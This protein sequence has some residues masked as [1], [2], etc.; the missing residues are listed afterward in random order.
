MDIV[1]SLNKDPFAIFAFILLIG[2]LGGEVAKRIP[3]LPKISGYIFAGFLIGPGV[4][5]IVD[6]EQLPQ[7]NIFINISLGLIMFEMGRYLHLPWFK[8]DKGLLPTVLIESFLTFIFTFVI[9]HFYGLPILTN[10]IISILL[11][12]T[13]PAIVMMVTYDLLAEGPVTRRTLLITSFNNLVCI[14]LYTLI[15]PLTQKVVT[16][17]SLTILYSLYQILGSVCLGIIIFLAA[18]YIALFLG[19]HREGQFV[20]YI[21]I[22]TLTIS[23]ATQLKLSTT[24]SLFFLG[25]AARNF[26]K[27]QALMEI[28]FGWFA[29]MFFIILFVT[30]G[31][32]LQFIQIKVVLFAIFTILIARFISK[33]IALRCFAKMSDLSKQQT[34]SIALALYPV[35]GAALGMAQVIG[36]NNPELNALVVPIVGSLVA[37]MH[38]LGPIATQYAFVKAKEALIIEN[39]E[40]R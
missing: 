9:L 3:F 14:V 27:K 6:T 36:E 19:K 39:P 35:G 37:I 13:A 24:I 22:V 12:G 25:V 33:Y 20:L 30:N 38:L 4:F 29:R 8:H 16:T 21:C 11:M 2:L 18:R 10:I 34:T 31:I 28:D 23:L 26:D 32:Y 5:N 15:L 7:I 17:H 1:F 40:R